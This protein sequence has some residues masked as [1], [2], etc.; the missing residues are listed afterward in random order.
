MTDYSPFKELYLKCFTEDTREDA[1]FLFENVLSKATLISKEYEGR[2]IAMLFLMESNLTEKGKT[3]PFYYLYAA[4]THPDFRGKGIMGELLASAKKTALLKG[5]MGIF[6]KPAT[7]SLF[8]FYAKYGFSP[9]FDYS[10]LRLPVSEFLK[11]NPTYCD[12]ETISLETWHTL[13]KEWL[14]NLCDI[15]ADFDKSLFLGATDGLTVAKTENAAVVYEIREDTLLIKE[16]LC[17]KEEKDSL[18]N[19]VSAL[20]KKSGVKNLELRM[21][22]TLNYKEF[23][24]LPLTSSPFSVIWCNE[25]FP[26]SKFKNAYHGF[27]FD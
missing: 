11:A 5:K 6:L 26:L 23:K 24:G 21:P 3:Y 4:C 1:D 9:F 13:R 12:F 10:Y 19:L 27:A 15:Y 17:I 7:K 25:S 2:P 20:A 8:D 16:A 22:K 18:L 14:P